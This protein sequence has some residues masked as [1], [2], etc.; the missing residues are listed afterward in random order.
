M[1][2]YEYIWVSKW[3]DGRLTELGAK[4]FRVCGHERS[5]SLLLMERESE[6]RDD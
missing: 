1:K 3:A 2:V 6:T 4:G 5:S